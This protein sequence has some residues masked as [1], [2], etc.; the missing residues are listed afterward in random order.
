MGTLRLALALL[1]VYFHTSMP[2]GGAVPDGRSAVQLFYLVSGFYMA[3]VLN[4]KYRTAE[5][6]WLF[7]TNRW[8][9][10]WP[11]IVVVNA[12][13]VLSFVVIG[14]VRLFGLAIEL[15]A[16]W[17][18]L[19]GLDASTL[20]YL[21]LTN[22]LVFGQDLL[23]FLRLDG[24]GMAYAPFPEPGH[25]G[26]AFSLNHPLFTVAIEAF[27]YL[28]SPFVLRR[29]WRVILGFVIVG[30]L[31][32]M[33]A[34]A[35][36]FSTL[37]WTYH[38]VGSAAYFF[39]LGALAYHLYRRLELPRAKAWL[40]TRRAV[41]WS[42]IGV[43]LLLVVAID[44]AL[45]RSTLFMAPVMAL[46]VPPLFALTRQARLDRLTGELSFGI[47]LTH[48]P[49]LVLLAPLAAPTMLWLLTSVLSILAALAL[50][51]LLE[52]P[53]DRWRQR[54]AAAPRRRSVDPDPLAG[55]R[56]LPA[57]PSPGWR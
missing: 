30:G 56:A 16:F 28:V 55:E 45:P 31:Y 17:S 2:L 40:A 53:I 20:L 4:E 23:W 39:F 54:R 5:S 43:G 37:I 21:G 41:A 48:Y 12:L 3:L 46:L 26:S 57:G 47:Y 19:A 10:L 44:A 14:E 42:A 13:V 27:Y 33:L 32:H 50:H 22:L 24:S 34:F 8:L 15:D 18:L 25:N 9:R 7:Y 51:Y 35:A 38:F 36:G 49:I 6:N 29:G 1:V 52:R 11:P